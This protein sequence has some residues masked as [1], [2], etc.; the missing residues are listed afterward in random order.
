MADEIRITV[1][2]WPSKPGICRVFHDGVLVAECPDSR[3]VET[4]V[5]ELRKDGF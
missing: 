2:T 5:A 1:R 4:V 3:V